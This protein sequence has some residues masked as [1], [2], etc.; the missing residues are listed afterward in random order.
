MATVVVAASLSVGC[1]GSSSKNHQRVVKASIADFDPNADFELKAWGSERPDDYEVQLAFNQTFT[2]MDDC[3][4]AAKIRAKVGPQ[5]QFEGDVRFE[6]R[7]DPER[8]RPLAVNAHLP[9][10]HADDRL[11]VDC[12]R[13]AVSTAHYPTYDG[14]P[15]VAE[16]ETQLDPGSEWVEE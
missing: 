16:F 14:P 13:E 15:I 2:A 7:L 3:V 6:V 8:A 11:L 5:R 9:Q 12:L 1:K 10:R 4:Y